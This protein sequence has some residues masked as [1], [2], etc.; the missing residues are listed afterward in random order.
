MRRFITG[1][2]SAL[3]LIV[4]FIWLCWL[5]VQVRGWLF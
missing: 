1:L 5:F 3:L 4:L 2:F